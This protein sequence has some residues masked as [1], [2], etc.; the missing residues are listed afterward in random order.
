[1]DTQGWQVVAEPPTEAGAQILLGLL[2]S[3]DIPARMQANVPVPGLGV[4]FKVEVKSDF[5]DRARDLLRNSQ[6]SD[7]ELAQLA[8]SSPP[9]EDG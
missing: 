7:E 8:T 3:E 2:Q 1:M 5:L 6:V 9:V 4:A